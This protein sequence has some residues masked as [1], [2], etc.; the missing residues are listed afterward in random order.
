[1]SYFVGWVKANILDRFSPGG[2]EEPKRATPNRGIKRSNPWLG[3][4]PPSAGNDEQ[5]QGKVR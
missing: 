3:Y 5:W 2:T 1:M 4:E